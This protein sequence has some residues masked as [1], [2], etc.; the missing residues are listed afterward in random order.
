MKA[1]RQASLPKQP[2]LKLERQL[3]E[4]SVSYPL[5]SAVTMIQHIF[6]LACTFFRKHSCSSCVCDHDRIVSSMS[7]ILPSAVCENESGRVK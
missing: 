4:L 2:Q 7:R 3:T 5:Q 6:P 1:T